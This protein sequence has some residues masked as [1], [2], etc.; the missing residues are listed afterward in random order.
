MKEGN[1][2]PILAKLAKRRTVETNKMKRLIYNRSVKGQSEPAGTSQTCEEK[3]CNNQ[4]IVATD[5]V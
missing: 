1:L 4:C 5:A 3:D 2:S